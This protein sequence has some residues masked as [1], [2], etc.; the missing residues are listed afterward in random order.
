MH[1]YVWFVCPLSNFTELLGRGEGEVIVGGYFPGLLASVCVYV[2][3]CIS[4][5]KT[6]SLR[7]NGGIHSSHSTTFLVVGCECQQLSYCLLE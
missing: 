2:C 3:V 6:E 1:L 7:S 5:G 4:G